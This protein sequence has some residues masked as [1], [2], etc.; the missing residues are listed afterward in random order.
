MNKNNT[1]RKK[2]LIILW[3]IIILALLN[4]CR[5]IIFDYDNDLIIRTLILMV[6][7]L[8]LLIKKERLVRIFSTLIFLVILCKCFCDLCTS[9]GT[10]FQNIASALCIL[11]V[12]VYFI[13][14]AVNLPVKARDLL[15]YSGTMAYLVA[16]TI[17]TVV[18]AFSLTPSLQQIRMN[19]D[20]N[21]YVKLFL[22]VIS[23]LA[24]FL[25]ACHF[26]NTNFDN[27]VVTVT[28]NEENSRETNM[29]K[30]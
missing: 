18:I 11:G 25:Y 23:W 13:A 5:G 6:S 30:N 26:S 22:G 28:E 27:P 19:S 24:I 17:Q 4:I 15:T 8:F 21:I 7:A 9:S 2:T 29:A 20:G 16:F 3:I 12:Q 14:V 10:V 1:N